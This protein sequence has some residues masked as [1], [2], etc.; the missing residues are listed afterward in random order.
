MTPLYRSLR[1]PGSVNKGDFGTEAGLFANELK[2]P[3]VVCGPGSMEQ[4]HKPDEFITLEQLG[5]CDAMLKRLL[6]Q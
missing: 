5:E 4:G 2:V 1:A 3:S 6:A